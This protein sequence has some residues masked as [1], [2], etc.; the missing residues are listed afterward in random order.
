MLCDV[1]LR[2]GLW[3]AVRCF[4]SPC[5]IC[6]PSENKYL[7]MI[8]FNS[9]WY[10]LG[11]CKSSRLFWWLNILFYQAGANVY[12][13]D[14]KF[15]LAKGL[16]LLKHIIICWHSGRIPKFVIL[17]VYKKFVM[18]AKCSCVYFIHGCFAK[19]LLLLLC[20]YFALMKLMMLLNWFIYHIK[21]WLIRTKTC[22]SLWSSWCGV[23]HFDW[24]ATI[25]TQKF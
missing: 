24:K 20:S 7:T 21:L 1:C 14:M 22:V 15:L 16:D 8:N 5:L 3:T 23:I 19:I 25:E 12:Y 17:I 11:Y 9:F 10:N 18:N 13:S 4:S 6:I 2:S